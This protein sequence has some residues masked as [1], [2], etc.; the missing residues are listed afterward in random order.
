M[1]RPRPGPT[2]HWSLLLVGIRT[3]S[4]SDRLHDHTLIVLSYEPDAKSPFAST[5]SDHTEP[6]CP[7]STCLHSPVSL[8]HTL[9]VLSHEPD[10]KSPFASTASEFTP[11]VCPFSTCLHSPVSLLHTLI[12]LSFEP[13]AKSPFASTASDHTQWVWAF[14]SPIQTPSNDL[15]RHFHSQHTLRD[16]HTSVW[17]CS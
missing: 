9:I 10:A 12:V 1:D 14:H 4:W 8:L 16:T 7:F 17:P 11:R 2:S 5:A 3:A 15:Y 13:D 6:V